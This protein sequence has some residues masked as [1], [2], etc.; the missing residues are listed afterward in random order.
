VSTTARDSKLAA[1]LREHFGFTDFRPGQVRAV[2]TALAGR[3]AVII[4]PT[5]SGKSVCFQLPGLELHGITLVASPLIALMKDQA[6]SLRERGIRV[7]VLNSSLSESEQR[8]TEQAI[9]A[10]D[11]E[12]VY[13]TPERIAQAEF[14]DLFK[15]QTIDLFVVDEAHCVSQWG[16]DF[17]PEYLEL[18]AAI[19]DLGGP[20]VLA[21]TATATPEVIDEIKAQLR[22]PEA[23]VI[24]TGFYRD[25]LFLAVE[26]LSGDAEKQTRLAELLGERSGSGIVYGATVKAVEETVKFLEA[27]GARV[28]GYHG[29][30]AA[31]RRAAAQDEFMNGSLQ[32]IVATNAFGLG[33][34]K[35]DIRFVIHLHAP[36]TIEAYYQEFGRAGRD[37]Q[38][39]DCTLFYDA[40]D[41]KLQ[42]F[43]QSGRY[44]DEGDLVNAYHA[45]ERLTNG[46]AAALADIQAISPLPKA[47]L[48]VCL[49]LFA[50][51]GVVATERGQRYRLLKPAMTRDQ[52]I[53][54]GRMYR[55]R[56]EHDL[57]GLQIMV[58]YAE[59]QACRWKKI[60]D[61]FHSDELALDRCGH[62][63]NCAPRRR[64]ENS[65]NC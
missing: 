47:R 21:L 23:E 45:L 1:R 57:V 36:A 42:R 13:T 43:F 26:S 25:N 3:D 22:I 28:A 35:P 4:M 37:G 46:R 14:R 24:H 34:D 11:V 40:E 27:R 63:D 12:F 17:R 55:D 10:G 31:R 38:S 29:R 62:C 19:A 5:G 53:Q 6:D 51:Q 64:L 15:S 59:R 52:L 30:M 50:N 9:R 32:A 7:A 18:G 60:L 65:D 49:A 41:R 61:H 56:R 2:R 8:A 20:S 58:E 33:I 48:K 16:H 44:P 54:C 39:A